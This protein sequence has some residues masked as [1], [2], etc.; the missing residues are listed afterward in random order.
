MS[1]DLVEP[2]VVPDKEEISIGTLNEKRAISHT[3]QPEL[4]HNV[5]SGDRTAE[6]DPIFKKRHPFV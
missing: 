1:Y 4:L 5:F 6:R 2:K 3:A